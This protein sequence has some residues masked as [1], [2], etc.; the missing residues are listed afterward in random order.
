MSNRS[1]ARKAAAYRR[2]QKDGLVVLRVAVEEAAI[3]HA[4]VEVGAL[5]RNKTDRSDIEA[6]LSRMLQDWADGWYS[7][8]L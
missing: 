2:R 1:S 5:D 6:A 3:T 4:L 7:L 8:D